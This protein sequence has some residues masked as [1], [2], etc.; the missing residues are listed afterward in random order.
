MTFP[1]NIEKRKDVSM[2]K[3]FFAVAAAMLI[4]ALS[5]GDSYNFLMLSDTHFGP[6]N[7]FGN[8]PPP[9][10]KKKLKRF[11]QA[12]HHYKAMFDDMA[13]KS[14][15]NTKFLIHAGD[16]IEGWAHSPEAQIEQ[17]RLLDKTLKEYF[18]MPLYMVRGNHEAA[19]MPGQE[20][21]L[22]EIA[23]TMAK[24]AGQAPGTV[25]YTVKQGD[26]LFIFLDSY[27]K[28][29]FS[30]VK[31]TLETLK[32]RPRYIFMVLHTDQL[33]QADKRAVEF[34]KLL[35]PYNAIILNGHTHRTRI[36]KYERDGKTVTQFSIGSFLMPNL[37]RYAKVNKDKETYLAKFR[38]SKHIPT[39]EKLKRFETEVAPF[40]TEYQEYVGKKGTPAGYARIHV[41]DAGVTVSVQCAYLEDK[42]FDIPLIVNK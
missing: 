14:D 6:E 23:P 21:Y 4:T 38:T 7:T 13:K 22:R 41:S 8:P 39:E 35:A 26:D 16:M 31:N 36:L 18:K 17:F 15:A 28:N 30:F 3:C 5:A 1:P 27:D 37:V 42:P 19:G 40:I 20:G 10:V 32:K 33:P 2:K 29:A 25:N 34:C 9:K 11:D 24:N 12:F